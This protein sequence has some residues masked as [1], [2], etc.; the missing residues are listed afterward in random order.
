MGKLAVAGQFKVS[1]CRG[2]G[3]ASQVGCLEVLT[4][5]PRLLVAEDVGQSSTGI[6]CHHCAFVHSVTQHLLNH[7]HLGGSVS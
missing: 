3:W 5:L 2:C 4:G 6:Y 1:C 7:G